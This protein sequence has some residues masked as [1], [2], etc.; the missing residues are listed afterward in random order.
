MQTILHGFS[1]EQLVVYLDDILLKET[2]FEKHLQLVD[3]VLTALESQGIKLNGRKCT[4]FQPEVKFLGHVINSSGLRKSPEYV[5]QIK[6][7]DK[8]RTVHQLRQFLGIVNYQRKFVQDCSTTA[9]PLSELTGLP[10][11]TVLTWTDEMVKSFEQLKSDMQADVTL[12]F[13]DY[14]PDASPLCLWVD[15]SAIGAGA[16]LNQEQDGQPRFIAF[17]SMTFTSA[18]RNYSVTGRELAALRWG[19]KTFHSFLCAVHFK[20]YTDHQA[21][22]YLHNMRLVNHGLARTVEELADYNYEIIYVPGR[23][24]F[25]ADLLSRMQVSSSSVVAGTDQSEELPDG[26]RLWYRPEGGG[27]TLIDCLRHWMTDKT[28]IPADSGDIR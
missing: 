14:R 6:Q 8:P 11:K 1:R 19:V 12:A 27:N 28:G 2:T 15:A 3:D 17:A 16:C 25:A 5:D 23:S 21:L 4:W 24:N 13:P 9:K 18:Q 22:S 26:L 10:S 7:L 20:I